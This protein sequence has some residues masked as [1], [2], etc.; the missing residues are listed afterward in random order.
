MLFGHLYL[1]SCKEN[2]KHFLGGLI[3]IRLQELHVL[4]MNLFIISLSCCIVLPKTSN[5]VSNISDEN[6]H[7]YL[8]PD[9]KD[10]L[11]NLSLFSMRLPVFYRCSLA[12][13]GHSHLVL[14]C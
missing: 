1:L 7:P 6:G 5:T 13:Q 10:I 4:N 12:P 8:V 14:V 9:L 2:N 3:F 11:F